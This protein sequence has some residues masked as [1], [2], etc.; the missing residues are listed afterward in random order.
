MLFISSSLS[1]LPS[2]L[3]ALCV[4]CIYTSMA[5]ARKALNEIT[6]MNNRAAAHGMMIA[7]NSIQYNPIEPTRS[8]RMHHRWCSKYVCT[9]KYFANVT[10]GK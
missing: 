3:L 4:L 2:I 9:F 7:F 8:K 6:H 1:L 10:F 5:L